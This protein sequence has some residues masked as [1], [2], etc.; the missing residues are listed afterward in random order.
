[1]RDT[2]IGTS[3]VSP[4]AHHDSNVVLITGG[5]DGIGLA[6][7]RSMAAAGH[8]VVVCGRDEQRLIAAQDAVLGLHAIR[9]DV[10]DQS[11]VTALLSD[12]ERRFGHLDV[13]VNNAG[14]QLNFRDGGWCVR[15]RRRTR[16]SGLRFRMR[17]VPVC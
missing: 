7:A 3:A 2:R 5:S 16:P 12:V 9:C 15:P 6:I 1:V 11:D 13:L 4:P 17:P 10:T 14:M 8:D